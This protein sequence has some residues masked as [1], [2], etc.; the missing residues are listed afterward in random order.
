MH[1]INAMKFHRIISDTCH[2]HDNDNNSIKIL[3][4]KRGKMQWNSKTF[5]LLAIS[6]DAVRLHGNTNRVIH[7]SIARYK[8]FF[9]STIKCCRCRA[10]NVC[11][12]HTWNNTQSLCPIRVHAFRWV[13]NRYINRL[14]NTHILCAF[15]SN[16]ICRWSNWTE[17][18]NRC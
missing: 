11:N 8:I 6:Y 3:K 10:I 5:N 16:K 12:I 14:Q 1:K 18:V 17:F 9:S 13:Y 4:I 2:D 15:Q 7:S